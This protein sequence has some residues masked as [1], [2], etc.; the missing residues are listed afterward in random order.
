M[1]IFLFIVTFISG[2]NLFIDLKKRDLFFEFEPIADIFKDGAG[3]ELIKLALFSPFTTAFLFILVMIELFGYVTNY[4]TANV[5]Y[6]IFLGV[7]LFITNMIQVGINIK[8]VKL[9]YIILLPILLILVSLMF[10]LIGIYNIYKNSTGKDDPMPYA[11]LDPKNSIY[12]K[13]IL[14]LEISII[15]FFLIY[16]VLFY[17]KGDKNMQFQLYVITCL[18]YLLSGG[19]MYLSSNVLKKKFLNKIS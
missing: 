18:I 9:A 11:Q 3:L 5:S 2:Y 16:F 19:I 1:I 13:I 4:A 10:I 8:C 15:I 6:I 17:T 7:L 12:Y 14:I